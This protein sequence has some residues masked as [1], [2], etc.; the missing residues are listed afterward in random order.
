MKRNIAIILLAIMALSV[1]AC[2]EKNRYG[3]N[4]DFS[5]PTIYDSGEADKEIETWVMQT[6]KTISFAM[7]KIEFQVDG[8][9]MVFPACASDVIIDAEYI[10]FDERLIPTGAE[11]ANIADTS[12][13]N[14]AV[15]LHM[16]NESGKE[17]YQ[18]EMACYKLHVEPRDY[19][20]DKFSINI[21]GVEIN[22]N[23]LPDDIIS[24][25]GEPGTRDGN[26][27]FYYFNKGYFEFD[28]H[29]YGFAGV[30]F[31]APGWD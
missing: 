1:T 11:F 16:D 29:E 17:L 10:D 28:F 6:N 20:Y 22:R 14:C 25:L 12:T 18:G 9:K 27:L 31:Y 3:K 4:P 23:T 13:E 7:D 30:W 8:Q 21:L 2:G 26:D 24:V 15:Y 19:A 5:D